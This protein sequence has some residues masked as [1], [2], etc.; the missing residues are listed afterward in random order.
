MQRNKG[1]WT[2][3]KRIKQL[4]RLLAFSMP[5]SQKKGQT[6]YSTVEHLQEEKLA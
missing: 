2:K 4:T 1:F 3:I 6:K 5:L